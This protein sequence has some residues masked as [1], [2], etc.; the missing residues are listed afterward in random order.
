MGWIVRAICRGR[1]PTA[2]T[3]RA[4]KKIHGPHR[5]VSIWIHAREKVVNFS[6]RPHGYGA[7]FS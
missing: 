5:G 7:S 6:K 3:A 2:L 1:H 4:L